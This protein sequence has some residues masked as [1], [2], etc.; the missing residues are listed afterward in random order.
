MDGTTSRLEK[1]RLEFESGI[2]WISGT[3]AFPGMRFQVVLSS[4][5]VPGTAKVPKN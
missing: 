5:Y 4:D 2:V 3:G 1:E